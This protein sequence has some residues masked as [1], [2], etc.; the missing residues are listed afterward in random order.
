MLTLSKTATKNGYIFLGSKNKFH[1][2][3]EVL[4]D[5]TCNFALAW[6]PFGTQR[7]TL[8]MFFAEKEVTTVLRNVDYTGKYI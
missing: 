6:F 2:E 7:C 5:W 8:E 4:V 3:K 1:F